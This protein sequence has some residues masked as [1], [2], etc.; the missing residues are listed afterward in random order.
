MYFLKQNCYFNLE[1]GSLEKLTL[2]INVSNSQN[3]YNTFIF[4]LLNETGNRDRYRHRHMFEYCMGQVPAFSVAVVKM[5]Q[6]GRKSMNGCFA[7][8]KSVCLG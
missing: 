4:Q 1:S 7:A 5:I 8:F 6:G 3:I 2:V